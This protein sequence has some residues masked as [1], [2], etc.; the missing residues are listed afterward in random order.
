MATSIVR[1]GLDISQSTLP[2][3]SPS[4]L[5]AFQPSRLALPSPWPAH[6]TQ[7]TL[8][9]RLR[10]IEPAGVHHPQ[11]AEGEVVLD[12]IERVEAAQ[13]GRDVARHPPARARIRRQAE[14]AA[15]ANHVGVERDNQPRPATRGARRRDRGRRAAPSSG[16]T[17][18]AACSRCPPRAAERNSRRPGAPGTRPYA[19][20]EIERQR[21][22]REAVERPRRRPPTLA[23]SPSSEERLDRSGAIDHLLQQPEQRDEV[24]A[25]RPAMDEAVERRAVAARIEARGRTRPA[26]DP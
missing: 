8:R 2:E 18:S 4:R 6:A 14:A 9:V 16:E 15:D 1:A 21:P 19:R 26:P 24:G 5:A 3:I 20:L 12:R 17:G 11:V 10:A 22:R 7:R 25:A 13:R 23:S